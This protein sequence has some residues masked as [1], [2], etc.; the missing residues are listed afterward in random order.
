MTGLIASKAGKYNSMPLSNML[1]S[2]KNGWILLSKT[3]LY[4]DAE[5]GPKAYPIKYAS[6]VTTDNDLNRFCRHATDDMIIICD[7][8]YD[9][10]SS[11]RRYSYRYRIIYDFTFSFLLSIMTTVS[12]DKKG[13]TD[14]FRGS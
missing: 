4:P 7:W 11:S 6:D 8:S 3:L 14:S 13:I 10:S 9:N 5:G 2:D 1:S 12:T